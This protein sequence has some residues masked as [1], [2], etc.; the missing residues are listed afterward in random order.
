MGKCYRCRA[1]WQMGVN[2]HRGDLDALLHARR[3][4]IKVAAKRKWRKVVTKVKPPK[5]PAVWNPLQIKYRSLQARYRGLMRYN[6]DP[7]KTQNCLKEL[8]EV[9]LVIKSNPF[10]LMVST[11]CLYIRAVLETAL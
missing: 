9:R 11:D 4:N 5:E 8:Q 7:V 10:A 2:G 1:L 3:W 6:L